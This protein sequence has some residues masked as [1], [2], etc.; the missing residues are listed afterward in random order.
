M[1]FRISSNEVPYGKSPHP[2]AYHT[3]E[4]WRIEV[5]SIEELDSLAE[6]GG[7]TIIT[8]NSNG[9]WIELTGAETVREELQDGAGVTL[10][11][12]RA[13]SERFA[14]LVRAIPPRDGDRHA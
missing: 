1:I 7:R 10:A 11:R 2:R 14:A 12:F 5:D 9:R 4:G 3:G 13:E 8:I 6:Y